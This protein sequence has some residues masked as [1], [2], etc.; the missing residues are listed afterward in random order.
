MI[1]K[2]L[3]ILQTKGV[4]GLIRAIYSRVY[5][6]LLPIKAKSFKK[7]NSQLKDKTGLEIGGLSEVFMTRG[8]FPVYSI[9]SRIDNCNFASSTIWEGTIDAGQNFQFN[10]K[11][12]NGWQ[13]ITEATALDKIQSESYDFVLSSH[14]LEHI[15]N[16]VLALTEWIRVLKEQGLLIL[17][18]PHKDGTFD[19]R[20][21][22]T[23]LEHL[24]LDFESKTKEDDLTHM[25]EILE[26]HDLSRDLAAGDIENFKAR[27]ERNA[28]NRCFHHH[29]F[30]THLAIELV[31]YMGLQIQAVE[32]IQPLHI[33]IIAKKL[34]KGELID[35]SLFTNTTAQFYKNSP[36][37]SDLLRG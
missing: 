36:F 33:L 2:I 26:L 17:L 19:H 31:D 35:N 16:P 34:S 32:T 8:I 9:A 11:K 27:S 21:P 37:P 29:V 14:A 20:R 28:E 25:A 12:L 5:N 30:D 13:Y 22:V 6:F 15:A 23:T 24:L 7:L 10:Q 1:K 18:L 4:L 3:N